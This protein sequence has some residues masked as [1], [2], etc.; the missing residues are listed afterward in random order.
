MGYSR[1]TDLRSSLLGVPSRLYPVS[2][3]ILVCFLFGLRRTDPLYQDFLEQD[4]KHT[5][6]PGTN[7]Q[8]YVVQH[9]SI[10][11]LIVVLSSSGCTILLTEHVRSQ[12]VPY[13]I[14]AWIAIIDVATGVLH[15]SVR[16]HPVSV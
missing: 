4:R 9:M 5:Y 8:S 3:C 11:P 16:H 13:N 12:F 15:L 10:N 7:P 2:W 1:K 14:L 6:L